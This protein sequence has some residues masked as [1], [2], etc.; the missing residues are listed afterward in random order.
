MVTSYKFPRSTPFKRSTWK[1][2]SVQNASDQMWIQDLNFGNI[3]ARQSNLMFTY[4]PVL[5][6]RSHTFLSHEVQAKDL[7]A[8]SLVCS[9]TRS[10]SVKLLLFACVTRTCEWYC[11]RCFGSW[12]NSIPKI[13][14]LNYNACKSFVS[15]IGKL[16]S[17]ICIE[18]IFQPIRVTVIVNRPAV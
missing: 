8:R 9:L 11:S 14:T 2:C 15:I 12:R 3:A 4:K 1:F 10:C 17:V 7:T 5:Y 18:K 6:C 16:N 13:G